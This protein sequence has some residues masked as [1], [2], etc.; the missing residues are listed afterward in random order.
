[1]STRDVGLNS[2]VERVYVHRHK[3]NSPQGIDVNKMVAEALSFQM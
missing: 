2:A 1:M 3:T